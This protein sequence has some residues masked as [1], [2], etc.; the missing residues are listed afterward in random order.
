MSR[1]HRQSEAADS[2]ETAALRDYAARMIAPRLDRMLAQAKDVE[3]GEEAEPIHQMR[4]WSRRTR[5]ALDMFHPCFPGK[6][7]AA[8]QCEV[9]AV[10]GAL[11]EAR[12]LDVM[13]DSLQKRADALPPAERAGLESFLDRLRDRRKKAQKAVRKAVRHLEHADPAGQF[14][15][16]TGLHSQNL[17]DAG[18]H[19]THG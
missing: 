19:G 14:E 16:M 11:G 4:V 1:A 9:K 12:D 2:P 18:T 13:I 10:T 17:S 7:Y 3:R 5:A 6:A 8:L 15:K